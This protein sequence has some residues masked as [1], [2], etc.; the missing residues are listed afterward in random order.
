[1]SAE[2]PVVAAAPTHRVMIAFKSGATLGPIP[3][4]FDIPDGAKNLIDDFA[5]FLDSKNTLQKKT[6][7]HLDNSII[8][9]DFNDVSA[10]YLTLIEC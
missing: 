5:L 8:S 7:Y 10:M 9:I 2:L 6:K 4:Q 1:M 3:A